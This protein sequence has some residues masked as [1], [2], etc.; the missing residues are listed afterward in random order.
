MFDFTHLKALLAEKR[1]N[2]PELVKDQTA[3]KSAKKQRYL[4][5]ELQNATQG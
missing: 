5:R 1:G 3:L 2:E 4:L